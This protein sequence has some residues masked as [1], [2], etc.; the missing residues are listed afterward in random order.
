VIYSC[1]RKVRSF[2]FGALDLLSPDTPEQADPAPGPERETAARRELAKV[3][4]TLSMLQREQREVI[5]LTGIVGLTQP[6]AA[7]ALGIT[8]KALEGASHGPA[9]AFA[10]YRTRQQCLSL[11]LSGRR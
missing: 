5:V 11:R 9:P 3:T 6:E 2:L 10:A 4:Q 1:F 7:A 8:L